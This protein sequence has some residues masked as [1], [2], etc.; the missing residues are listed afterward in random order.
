MAGLHYLIYKNSGS[1]CGFGA[2]GWQ[3]FLGLNFFPGK[4]LQYF[5]FALRE[6]ATVGTRVA[7]SLATAYYG[8]I[9]MS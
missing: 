9:I 2:S 7:Y 1:S 8:L 4:V 5:H 3:T 6:M